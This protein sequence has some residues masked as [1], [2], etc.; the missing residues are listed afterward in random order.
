MME[1]AT[2]PPPT[3]PARLTSEADWS[4]FVDVYGRAVLDWFRQADVSLVEADELTREVL[5]LLAREFL[6]I[7]NAPDIRFRAWLQYAG[8]AVWCKLMEE[9]VGDGERPGSNLVNL[10][11]SVEAHDHFLKMLDTECSKQRRR[12]ALIRVQPQA[13]PA[14]WEAF[15][16]T[17]LEGQSPVEVAAHLQAS[18]LAVRAAMFRVRRLLAQVLKELEDHG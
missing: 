8:H 7:A 17:V 11:L 16:L 5:E 14:D 3:G 13:D 1:P 9:R 2:A 6:Q 15:Y 4:A 10:L 18:E 12:E